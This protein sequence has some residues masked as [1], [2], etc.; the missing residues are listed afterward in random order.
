VLLPTKGVSTERALLT[1]G[2]RI[3]DQLREPSSVTTI[4]DRFNAGER[5][6]IANTRVTF[7]WFCLALASLYAMGLVDTSEDGSIGRINVS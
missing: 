5:S 2:M 6:S 4:W 7:D 1:I 3:L